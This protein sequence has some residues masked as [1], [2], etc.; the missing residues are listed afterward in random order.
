MDNRYIFKAIVCFNSINYMLWYVN[1]ICSYLDVRKPQF[2][3]PLQPVSAREGQAVH[4]E[5]TF[6]GEPTPQIQWMKA[7]RP[8]V[9]SAVFKV[10]KWFNNLTCAFKNIIL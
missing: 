7:D 8:I 5:C 1:I 10:S 6:S 9:Q 3:S 4:L 2:S